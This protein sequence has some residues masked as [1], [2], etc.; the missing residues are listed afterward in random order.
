MISVVICAF[1]LDRWDQLREA[2]GSVLDQSHPAHEVIL[3]VDHS[4]ELLERARAE[5]P[6]VRALPSEDG[7]GLSGA[8]NTGVRHARGDVVA[9]MDD[10]ARADRDWLASI[11][12]WYEDPLT[13][14]VG[15]HIDPLWEGQAPP[16]F[17]PEL[18]WAVGGTHTGVPTTVAPV[19]NLFGSN[20]SFRREA[21][22]ESGGFRSD[23]GRVGSAGMN[24][25]ET[26]LAI[27]ASLMRPGSVVLHVPAA[28]VAHRVGRGNASWGY[29]V[30][31]CWAEGL[32]K[33]LVTRYVGSRSGLSSE[34]AYV[35][36]VLPRGVAAGLRDALRGDRHGLA[37][38]AAIA[39]ALTTTGAAYGYGRAVPGR[40]SRSRTGG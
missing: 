5:L 15:G 9:F 11:A 27:R 25:E 19:R 13:I 21:L 2:V 23:M 33:A 17:P 36:R 8:R 18:H 16:W 1:T 31:R 14:G 4:D 39:V 24:C 22:E 29:L 10:D 28:R 34:R 7:A 6:G 26:E 20:M 37:R 38:A 12:P 40:L 30:R 32:S 3:V 35:A